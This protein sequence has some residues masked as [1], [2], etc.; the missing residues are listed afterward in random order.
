ME[1]DYNLLVAFPD[2]S[3]SFVH[4]FEAGTIWQRMQT[5]ETPI[6]ATLHFA[7]TEVF[8]RMAE[9][10]GYGMV[11][12]ETDF[13]EWVD[14]DFILMPDEPRTKLRLIEGGLGHKGSDQ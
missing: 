14:V 1:N 11:S 6:E 8:S 2:G 9:A 10:A 13:P 12:K 5:K 7:N 3:P 4:G